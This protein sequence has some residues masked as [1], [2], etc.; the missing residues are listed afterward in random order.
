MIYASDTCSIALNYLPDPV[1][2]ADLR[3]WV[4]DLADY[5]KR[6]DQKAG[7]GQAVTQDCGAVARSGG[8]GLIHDGMVPADLTAWGLR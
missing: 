2:E 6:I 4:E 8:T 7:G 1:S 5:E 3:S